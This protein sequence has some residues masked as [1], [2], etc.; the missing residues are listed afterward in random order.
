MLFYFYETLTAFNKLKIM[1]D[2]ILLLQNTDN[3]Q[4]VEYYVR[5]CFTSPLS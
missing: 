3:L 1:S 5:G 2:V 4:Q